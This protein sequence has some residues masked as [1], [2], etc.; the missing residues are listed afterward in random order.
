MLGGTGSSIQRDLTRIAEAADASSPEGVSHLLTG[1]V[2][3]S[4]YFFYFLII[5]WVLLYTHTH[6]HTHTH[7]HS[8]MSSNQI[9]E[10]KL[11][12]NN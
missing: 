7:N 2:R 3:N 5:K 1:S 4:L 8:R 9:T 12:Q 6:T 11:T 10:L